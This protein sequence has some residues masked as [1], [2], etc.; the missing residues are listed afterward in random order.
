LV[1]T[2]LNLPR[3]LSAQFLHP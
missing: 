2:F 1:I 3:G